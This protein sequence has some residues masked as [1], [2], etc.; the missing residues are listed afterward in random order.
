M[1]AI[2]Y[3]IV[4]CSYRGYWTSRGRPSEDG[5]A[6][7]AESAMK[8]IGEM[9]RNSHGAPHAESAPLIIWGQ[10]I[11]AGVATSLAA[12][13]HLFSEN[14]LVLKTII[15]ETPFISI[16]A[17]LETLYPQ[18]WLPYKYLWPFLRNHLD[19]PRA[20]FKMKE[21]C[22]SNGHSVPKILI[23]EAG[24]DELV[25]KEHGDQLQRICFELGLKV[26][27]KV[28]GGALHTEVMVRPQGRLAVVEA[29]EN[30]SE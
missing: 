19:S 27:R 20:L 2:Q 10:S 11:G 9:H 30:A 5:I 26:E 16:K 18:K 3:T 1:I 14:N 17:M 28:V 13:S 24:N 25:P 15:L 7:D 22:E 29:I 12:R 8:W 21:N 4:C 23:L 6:K